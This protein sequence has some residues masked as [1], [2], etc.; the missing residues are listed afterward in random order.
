MAAILLG[1]RGAERTAVTASDG[2]ADDAAG[3]LTGFGL[4]QLEAGDVGGRKLRSERYRRKWD[5]R[6]RR[7]EIWTRPLL[8]PLVS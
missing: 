3:C 7:R 2:A 1:H 4:V 8:Q 6:S 5:G